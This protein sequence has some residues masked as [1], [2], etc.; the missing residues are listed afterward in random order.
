[1]PDSCPLPSL[2]SILTSSREDREDSHDDEKWEGHCEEEDEEWYGLDSDEEM[3]SFE[4]SKCGAEQPDLEEHN[5]RLGILAWFVFRSN[6]AF[7]YADCYVTQ[8][9]KGSPPWPC[10]T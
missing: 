5:L 8:I 4:E 7:G 9:Y 1:M 3:V 6:T 10:R 2:P